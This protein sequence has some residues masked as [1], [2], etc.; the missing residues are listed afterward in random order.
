MNEEYQK[1]KRN[2]RQNLI[3][4]NFFLV[5]CEKREK[6]G[7]HCGSNSLCGF[8]DQVFFFVCE[9]FLRRLSLH[10]IE[11]ELFFLKVFFSVVLFLSTF[12][13]RICV[14]VKWKAKFAYELNSNRS[15]RKKNRLKL[16]WNETSTKL[17]FCWCFCYRSLLICFSLLLVR[18]R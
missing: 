1:K 8:L 9:Y 7:I 12:V 11:S 15:K 5:R 17:P 14:F 6:C 3:K 10:C 18:E 13:R 4:E 2:K 16:K